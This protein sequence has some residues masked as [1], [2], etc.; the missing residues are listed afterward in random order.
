MLVSVLK[1]NRSKGIE[2][3]LIEIKTEGVLSEENDEKGTIGKSNKAKK[4]N[5]LIWAG[6]QQKRKRAREQ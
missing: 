1:E 3:S 2:G 4:E 5:V 6:G